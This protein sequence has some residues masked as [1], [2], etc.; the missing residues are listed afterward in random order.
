MELELPKLRE[1][2]IDI[3]CER[4]TFPTETPRPINCPPHITR[5]DISASTVYQPIFYSNPRAPK[6]FPL[7]NILSTVLDLKSLKL[8]NVATSDTVQLISSKFKSLTNLDLSYGI[9]NVSSIDPILK[10]CR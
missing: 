9:G 7:S 10:E 3:D 6:E 4:F 2:V 8:L 5:L 1:L